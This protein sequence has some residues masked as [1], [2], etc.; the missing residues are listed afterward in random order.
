[1]E[2]RQLREVELPAHPLAK[3]TEQYVMG[4]LEDTTLRGLGIVVV[5]P[6]VLFISEV[7]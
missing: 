4:C 7:I 3:G 2:R 5:I 1:M 6:M